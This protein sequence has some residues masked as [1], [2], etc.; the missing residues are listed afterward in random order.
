MYTNW[1][2][3]TALNSWP[4]SLGATESLTPEQ[5]DA[6][7]REDAHYEALVRRT[8]KVHEH[9]FNTLAKRLM[10]AGRNKPAR[11]TSV[12]APVLLKM[13][14]QEAQAVKN[15]GLWRVEFVVNPK[16]NF[17]DVEEA[18]TYCD[19]LYVYCSNTPSE[20]SDNRWKSHFLLKNHWY[21][22]FRD[23]SNNIK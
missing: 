4:G 15:A 21:F 6:E 3:S 19:A 11:L 10:A 2:I 9:E 18:Y 16:N 22:F 20:M 14:I 12:Q 5:I 17:G 13:Q 1:S 8:F 7:K 23:K